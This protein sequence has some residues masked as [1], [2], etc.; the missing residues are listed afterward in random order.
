MNVYHFF[1]YKEKKESECK[2]PHGASA[3]NENSRLEQNIGELMYKQ[4][5]TTV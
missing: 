1:L 5:Q 3:K 4:Q 2:T